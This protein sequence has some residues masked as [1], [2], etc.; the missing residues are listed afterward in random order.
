[1]SSLR[2][3]LSGAVIWG[4][5]ILTPWMSFPST[6]CRC[7]DGGF[8]LFCDAHRHLAPN[9]LAVQPLVAKVDCCQH[10]NAVAQRD[11]RDRANRQVSSQGCTPVTN[12]PAVAPVPHK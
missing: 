3:R 8:K 10:G 11:C 2:R 6:A 12:P 9:G 1:M 7:A 4:M 5:V